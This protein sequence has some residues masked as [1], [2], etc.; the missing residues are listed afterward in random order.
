MQRSLEAY[1][2]S[3][4]LARQADVLS[5]LGAV[6]HWAGRWDEA[7]SYCERGGEEAPEDRRYGR[8]GLDP[9]QCRRDPDRPW[10]MGRGRSVGAGNA[11]SVE[12]VAVSLLPGRLPLVPRTSV[13]LRWVV[14]MTRYAI[15]KRPSPTTGRSERKEKV[16]AVDARIAECRIAMGTADAALELVRGMLRR[17]SESQRRG[18]GGVA[19]AACARPRA[20]PAGR[21]AGRAERAGRKSRRSA[22]AERSLRDGSYAALADRARPARG[23][24]ASPSGWWKRAAPFSPA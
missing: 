3:G 24:R 18:E 10:R 7:L 4:N 21:S 15:S 11:A 6:C 20:A 12:G 22:G 1:Q 17:V 8:C 2:R 9:H 13:A 5:N 16:P 23:R 14:S 19:S